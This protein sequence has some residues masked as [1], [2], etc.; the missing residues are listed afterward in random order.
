MQSGVKAEKDVF[1]MLFI[2]LGN[3]EIPFQITYFLIV[4]IGPVTVVSARM[5]E[6]ADAPDLESGRET[7]GGSSPPPRTGDRQGRRDFLGKLERIIRR[8]SDCVRA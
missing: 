5:A 8:E 3:I 6:L 1:Q 7:C 4:I 2:G